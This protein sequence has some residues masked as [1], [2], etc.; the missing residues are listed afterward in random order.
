MQYQFVK[1][2][3]RFDG[4]GAEKGY[5]SLFKKI[6]SDGKHSISRKEWREY[7]KEDEP[8]V[9]SGKTRFRDVDENNNKKIGPGE[10]KKF[11][12]RLIKD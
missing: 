4:D 11:Y 5:L 10:F 3:Q 6:N 9:T 2:L 1:S 7:K 8:E 12:E